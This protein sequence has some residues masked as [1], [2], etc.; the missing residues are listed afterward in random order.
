MKKAILGAILTVSILAG[1]FSFAPS[2]HAAW[3]NPFSWGT[4][5]SETPQPA[6]PEQGQKNVDRE[7]LLQTILEKDREIEVLKNNNIQTVQDV[8]AVNKADSPSK[9]DPQIRTLQMALDNANRTIKDLRAQVES[10]KAQIAILSSAQKT[11]QP[12]PSVSK[13]VSQP[14]EPVQ[15]NYSSYPNL[16]TTRF[17]AKNPLPYFG[18]PIML[19]DGLVAGFSPAVDPA[20]DSSYVRL[21]DYT[22]TPADL[23]E[24]A[25]KLDDVGDFTETAK[26]LKSGDRVIVYGIGA[27]SVG[28]KSGEFRTAGGGSSL[29][30]AEYIPVI[31]LQRILKCGKD[32]DDPYFI[33]SK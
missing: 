22:G 23:G 4:K 3:W 8:P 20:T 1:L 33:F 32:C 10:L 27:R 17:Y 29:F 28:V 26:Q 6:A 7:Q 13:P 5:R 12:S 2:A 15:I 16:G 24:V 18:K 21:V 25:L 14:T 11:T 19:K 9:T 30:I 31:I